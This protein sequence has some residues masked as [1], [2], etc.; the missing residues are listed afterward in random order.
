MPKDMVLKTYLP[1]HGPA[2]HTNAN[3]IHQILTNL[4][5]NARESVGDGSGSIHLSVKTVS[6]ADIATLHRFPQNW[7]PLDHAYACLEVKDMG[8]GIKE[9]DIEMLFDPFFTSKFTGRGMGLAVV[10]GIVRAHGGVVTVESEP[11]RGSIFRAYFPVY[12]EGA[13]KATPDPE[14]RGAQGPAGRRREDGA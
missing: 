1:S 9:K 3:Y 13:D 5:T 11:G 4:V 6:P 2:I 14:R 12:A 7:R 8:S 10:L